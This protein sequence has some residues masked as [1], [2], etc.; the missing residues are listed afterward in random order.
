MPAK[1]TARELMPRFPEEHEESA[2]AAKRPRLESPGLR[3][4]GRPY[5]DYVDDEAR[6]Y[7]QD[8]VNVGSLNKPN[9]QEIRTAATPILGRALHRRQ[10][11]V[12]DP[13]L[14]HYR[15]HQGVSAMQ[16]HAAERG[17]IKHPFTLSETSPNY[18]EALIQLADDANWL[19]REIPL[20]A[21]P[22]PHHPTIYYTIDQVSNRPVPRQDSVIRGDY[23]Y[24]PYGGNQFVE[25]GDIYPWW[26]SRRIPAKRELID[27]G[28][29]ACYTLV[30]DEEKMWINVHWL[31]PNG[32]LFF[33]HSIPLKY[34]HF[35]PQPPVV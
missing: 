3:S 16:L 17:W 10:G 21:H 12:P 13:A 1:R 32:C 20:P 33:V 24:S 2:P 8:I 22:E 26:G 14:S 6:R 4:P 5:Q 25:N 23:V 7:W 35:S 34:L 15:A 18:V 29:M 28:W 30:S 11:R 9:Q 31:N 19:A 27:R